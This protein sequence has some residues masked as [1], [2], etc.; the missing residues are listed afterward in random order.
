MNNKVFLDFCD[1]NEETINELYVEKHFETV[2]HG[3]DY[4][5]F[6]NQYFDENLWLD[7]AEELYYNVIEEN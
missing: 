5:P 7:L 6:D 1:K 4:D 2:G 3:G